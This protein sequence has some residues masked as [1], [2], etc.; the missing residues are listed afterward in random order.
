[1]QGQ[2]LTCM[3]ESCS[4]NRGEECCAPI[5]EVG[6]DH[7]VCDMYTTQPV[8]SAGAE[9]MIQDCFVTDC[10]F[11]QS[12]ACKASGVTFTEH[13]GHADCGTFRI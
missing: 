8:Q 13:K 3:A 2:V 5:V 10:H 11:N 4:Y 1:M 6:S 12:K 7:Q 9:P